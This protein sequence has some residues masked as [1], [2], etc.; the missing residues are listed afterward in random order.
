MKEDA[1]LGQNLAVL[2]LRDN[3][4]GNIGCE[5]MVQ[6][7]HQNNKL[8][9]LDISANLLE[10]RALYYVAEM[11]K[12]N[13]SI[14]FLSCL[15]NSFTAKVLYTFAKALCHNTTSSLQVLKLGQVT[16]SEVEMTKFIANGLALSNLHFLYIT[17]NQYNL[18]VIESVNG[19][20][21]TALTV[22]AT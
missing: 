2:D 5:S 16:C 20:T 3:K 17:T 6:Q 11:L 15:G 1:Y 18:P 12:H 10:D 9:Y 21:E 22:H 7:L 19:S 14:R 8:K 13:Q 4:I